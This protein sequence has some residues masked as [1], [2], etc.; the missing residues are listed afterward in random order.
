MRSRLGFLCLD[1]QSCLFDNVN[2]MNDLTAES[3]E[4]AE[5]EKR[6]VIGIDLIFSG[7]EHY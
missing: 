5:A 1:F 3:A 2:Y 7:K 4:G 6:E